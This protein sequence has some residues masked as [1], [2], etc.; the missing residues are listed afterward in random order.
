[1][2][3]ATEA[4]RHLA[5]AKDTQAERAGAETGSQDCLAP[6]P[7]LFLLRPLSHRGLERHMHI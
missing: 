5:V 6:E 4:Q 3:G 1:M 2:D 7:M